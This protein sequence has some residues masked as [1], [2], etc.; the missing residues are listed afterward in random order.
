VD[1]GGFA[2]TGADDGSG[3]RVAG[4]GDDVSGDFFFGM[5]EKIPWGEGATSI[6]A[7]QPWRIAIDDAETLFR[8]RSRTP[9]ECATSSIANFLHLFRF[10]LSRRLGCFSLW[11]E[12]RNSEFSS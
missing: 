10:G 3:I 9:L 2:A 1:D 12:V 4:L 11:A 5:H 6:C 7:L 8:E